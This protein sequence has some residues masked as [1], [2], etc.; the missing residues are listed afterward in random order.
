MTSVT[1]ITGL[2]RCLVANKLLPESSAKAA[3]EAAHASGQTLA[4]YLVHN[5]LLSSP[6]IATAASQEFGLPLLDLDTFDSRSIPLDSIDQKLMIKHQILP[7]YKRDQRLYIA[8][9]DPSQLDSISEVKFH[10]GNTIEVIVV[11][12]DKLERCIRNL[13]D[14]SDSTLAGLSELEA[15]GLEEVDELDEYSATAIREPDAGQV[16][17]R[18]NADEA[19]IVRFVNKVMRDAIRSGASD[20]HL[21]PYEKLY[22]VR[23]R[24]DGILQEIARPP[25]SIAN[26]ICSRIKIMAG[27]DISE[28]RVPQDGRIKLKLSATRAIDFRVNT[29][30]TLW[31]EK[32]ALRILDPNSANLGIDSLG[33]NSEQKQQYLEALQLQQ[34]MILVTGPTGS[35][36]TVSLYTG[37]SLLNTHERNISTAEDPVEINLEGINQVAVKARVGLN[38]AAALRAFL[39]Q[40]PDVVMVGEMRDLE[41]AEIAIKAAQTGHLVL[42]TLHTNNAA[43]TL[44]RLMNM[45]VPAYNVATSVSLIIAQRLVRRLC[46][47][48]KQALTLSSKELLQA[49]FQH[50]HS[51]GLQAYSASGCD[52][53]HEGYK[54]RL[55]I[56]EVVPVTNRIARLIMDNG[57]SLQIADQARKEG[58]IDLRSAA[59][60]KVAQ[61]LTSLTEVNRVT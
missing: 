57:N 19:P 48:C 12:A 25:L 27:M 34:G 50:E 38:F 44:T 59:L 49:G 5:H 1:H 14:A 7:L 2:A 36:K 61:G 53:C 24:Q 30:P 54:G 43:E 26:K 18:D 29:L 17:A 40:D 3:I 22:R 47:H 32:V 4:Q 46:P 28:R 56:Y 31:G 21:E 11:E 52:Q 45:G 41:T 39:R 9:A 10:T 42:S 15:L 33:F 13:L 51:D 8:L 20:I 58:F 6:V 55:G 35:G 16:E 60:E 37:L 23:F